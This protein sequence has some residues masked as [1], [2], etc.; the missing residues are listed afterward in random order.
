MGWFQERVSVIETVSGDILDCPAQGHEHQPRLPQGKL[1]GSMGRH[2]EVDMAVQRARDLE[3]VTEHQVTGR[4][5]AKLSAFCRYE[6]ALSP[7]PS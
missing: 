2:C 6:P 4:N 7:P 5:R 3:A 1:V